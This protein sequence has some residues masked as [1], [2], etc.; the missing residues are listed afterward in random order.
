MVAERI[1]CASLGLDSVACFD[2]LLEY[3]V[4]DNPTETALDILKA[5][6]V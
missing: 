6:L 1:A 2:L 3:V 5:E 4:G